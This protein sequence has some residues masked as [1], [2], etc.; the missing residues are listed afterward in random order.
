MPI[1]EPQ[2]E[3]RSVDSAFRFLTAEE[4]PREIYRI[5][6]N[7]R[8]SCPMTQTKKLTAEDVMRYRENMPMF[9]VPRN[10]QQ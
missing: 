5:G 8:I 9:G 10:G 1:N 2:G 6:A 3:E 4:A 7:S